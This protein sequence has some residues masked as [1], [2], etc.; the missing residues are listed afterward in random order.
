MIYILCKKD[1][2]HLYNA[3][4]VLYMK[5]GLYEGLFLTIFNSFYFLL[6][7]LY[8]TRVLDTHP[9]TIITTNSSSSSR[10]LVHTHI[11]VALSP[12]RRHLDKIVVEMVSVAI[13]LAGLQNHLLL[14]PRT[15]LNVGAQLNCHL[16][17]YNPYEPHHYS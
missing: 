6:L 4:C 5:R 13:N 15:H 16:A 1:V 12:L 2:Q 11:E 3:E 9:N 10:I 14:Q 8:F 7:R 17:N